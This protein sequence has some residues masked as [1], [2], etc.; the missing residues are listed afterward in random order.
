MQEEHGWLPKYEELS[1]GKWGLMIALAE[2]VSKVLK[3]PVNALARKGDPGVDLTKVPEYLRMNSQKPERAI[4]FGVYAVLTPVFGSLPV[5]AKGA[6]T[7]LFGRPGNLF[8]AG[9]AKNGFVPVAAITPHSVTD[10]EKLARTRELQCGKYTLLR[11]RA[12]TKYLGASIPEVLDVSRERLEISWAGGDTPLRFRLDYAVSGETVAG[13]EPEFATGLILPT[14]D[15]LY[16]I[17]NE[18]HFSE[19]IILAIKRDIQETLGYRRGIALRHHPSRGLYATRFVYYRT[20]GDKAAHEKVGFFSGQ[21]IRDF[22][23]IEPMLRNS[24]P[25][26]GRSVLSAFG[27]VS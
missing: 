17:G 9:D 1:K 7:E 5:W 20:N 2:H 10:P 19:N 16:L 25:F 13:K 14:Y 22:S 27:E 3:I 15:H 21:D 8:H 24:V 11:Y 6:Y 26:D 12:Q 4:F 23:E 18:Q